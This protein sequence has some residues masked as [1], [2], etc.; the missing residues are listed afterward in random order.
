MA[1]APRPSRVAG[2]PLGADLAR[3]RLAAQPFEL[4]DS[5]GVEG[6]KSSPGLD[7]TESYWLAR[8]RGVETD[9]SSLVLAWRDEGACK[10]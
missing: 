9:G 1:A 6:K 7:L 2:S 10:P 3:L 5:Y 8:V 4:G